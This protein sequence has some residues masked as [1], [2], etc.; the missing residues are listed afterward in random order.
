MCTCIHILKG[1]MAERFV[2]TCWNEEP[3]K[4]PTNNGE[5]DSDSDDEQVC[6]RTCFL[7]TYNTLSC[8]AVL[9]M[10]VHVSKG[11]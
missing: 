9:P 11:T 4:D 10:Q 8:A 3:T 1:A 7:I 5:T 2:N 6:I